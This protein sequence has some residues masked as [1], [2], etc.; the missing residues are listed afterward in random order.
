[1]FVGETGGDAAAGGAVEEADLDKEGFVDLFGGGGEGVEADRATVV[2]FDDGA[3][4]A[5]VELV[6]AVGVDFEQLEGGDGRGAVDLAGGANL[7]IVADAAQ[8]AVGDA[9]CAAGAHGDLGGA[10][11]VDRN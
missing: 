5:A 2:F 7:G 11:V 6:E 10:V 9:G 3:K 4:Q 1:M 8:E